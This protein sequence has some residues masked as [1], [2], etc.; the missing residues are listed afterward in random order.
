[1]GS[2]VSALPIVSI[3]KVCATI[4]LSI[5]AL[6]LSTQR[7]CNQEHLCEDGLVWVLGVNVAVI[8]V[9]PRSRVLDPGTAIRAID[10]VSGESRRS[11]S[12]ATYASQS[13]NLIIGPSSSTQYSF[14]VM[15]MS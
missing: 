5:I 2:W 7:G 1:M 6:H 10:L 4:K 11:G 14:L 12:E 8:P 13:S 15:W 9:E 3:V